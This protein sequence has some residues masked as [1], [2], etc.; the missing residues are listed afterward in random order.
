MKLII[1]RLMQNLVSFTMLNKRDS[2]PKRTR[3]NKKSLPKNP[4]KHNKTS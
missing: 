4:V 2:K 3:D 1:I